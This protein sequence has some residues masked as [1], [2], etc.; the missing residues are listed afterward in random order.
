MAY[1]DVVFV[2][3]FMEFCVS[4]QVQEVLADYSQKSVA[5]ICL[6]AL[7][8][9]GRGGGLNPFLCLLHLFARCFSFFLL[10]SF[11]RMSESLRVYF[12]SHFVRKWG[13]SFENIVVGD[14]ECPSD[15]Y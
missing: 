12:S 5:D 9:W 2:E 15:Y 14:V 8:E 13:S 11:L 7:T 6:G 3:G 4:G 10:H 1:F